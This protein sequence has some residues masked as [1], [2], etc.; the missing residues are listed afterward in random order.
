[1][2]INVNIDDALLE[3]LS[4]AAKKKRSRQ[5]TALT[6]ELVEEASRIEA[7]RRDENSSSEVIQCDV[8]AAV[9]FKK[10]F[11]GQSKVTRKTKILKVLLVV[12]TWFSG[13]LFDPSSF[14]ANTILLY[15]FLL[16]LIV[17]VALTVYFIFYNDGR[18]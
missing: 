18:E 15:L 13:W 10:V 8:T 9:L 16:C 5:A 17:A 11:N 2:D 14:S 7:G 6:H 4:S 1:M 3:R 12:D